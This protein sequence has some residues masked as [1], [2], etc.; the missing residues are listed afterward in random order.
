MVLFQVPAGVC[1]YGYI[2]RALRRSQ[3]TQID[4]FTLHLLGIGRIGGGR[5]VNMQVR[6]VGDIQMIQVNQVLSVGGPPD[7]HIA[8]AVI[9]VKTHP[10]IGFVDK[11]PGCQDDWTCRYC[12]Y[13]RR[14]GA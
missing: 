3:Q 4:A 9:V 11:L 10:G 13:W 2:H 6:A 7:G 1:R 14:Y 12:W 8:G 5:Q